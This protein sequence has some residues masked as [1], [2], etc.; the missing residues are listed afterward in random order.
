[1]AAGLLLRVGIS[2]LLEASRGRQSV[3]W[4][5]LGVTEA[6]MLY[7]DLQ[8]GVFFAFV[9][10]VLLSEVP[11]RILL[12][13]WRRLIVLFP[14][15]AAVATLVAYPLIRGLVDGY[16]SVTASAPWVASVDVLVGN[17]G[18]VAG[19]MLPRAGSDG[20]SL[21][22]YRLL[23]GVPPSGFE[24]GPE[25]KVYLGLLRWQ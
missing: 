23:G 2:S 8:Y 22:W 5:G 16:E 20:G 9:L 14:L 17:S 13:C 1:M 10:P 18:Y 15:S 12:L 3:S 21:L 6:L 7:S 11:G 4:L 19:F 25:S 24:P